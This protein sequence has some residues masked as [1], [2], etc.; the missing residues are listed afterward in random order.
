MKGGGCFNR[1]ASA[2]ILKNVKTDAEP[3]ILHDS[4]R[5]VTAQTVGTQTPAI[6]SALSRP[7]SPSAR[8]SHSLSDYPPLYDFSRRPH[9]RPPSNVRTTPSIPDSVCRSSPTRRAHSLSDYP[10][11]YDF[12]RRPQIRQ[13]SLGSSYRNAAPDPNFYR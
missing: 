11:L 5:R 13:G 7:A 8:R 1:T 12:S 3:E 9:I 10:P 4:P 2:E 6:P